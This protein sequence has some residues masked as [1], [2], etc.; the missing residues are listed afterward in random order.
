MVADPL[1]NFGFNTD[2][3]ILMLIKLLYLILFVKKTALN[4]HNV[5]N[6]SLS[7]EWATTQR[8]TA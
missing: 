2:N 5:L 4:L 1:L 3:E 6:R 8:Q 7:V